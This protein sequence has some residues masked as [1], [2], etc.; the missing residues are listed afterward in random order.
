M[1]ICSS[2]SFAASH[3][4]SGLLV[5]RSPNR[6]TSSG[7][8]SLGPF[9]RDGVVGGDQQRAIVRP[10]PQL[11]GGLGQDRIARGR[12]QLRDRPAE[13]GIGLPPGH[14]QAAGRGLDPLGEPIEHRLVGARS[15]RRYGVKGRIAPPFER[16]RIRGRHLTLHRNGSEWLPP[17]NVEMHRTRAEV[18]QRQGVG[19]AGNRAEV[20]EALVVRHMRADFA[21]PADRIAVELELVDRLARADVAELRRPIGSEH[22]HRHTRLVG[23]DDGRVEVGGGRSGGAQH[24]GRDP[25]GEGR[26]EREEAGA[27]LIED[28][29]SPRSRAAARGRRRVGWSASRARGPPCGRRS[30]PAPRPSRRRGR[31]CGWLRPPPER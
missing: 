27:A 4:R 13:P 24:D 15:S 14:D 8:R 30:G 31:C 22:D 28:H 16:E 21:E 12:G 2:S 11:G 5:G 9:P 18:T 23:L 17:G 25:G 26:P 3:C 1:T 7:A 10:P 6:I 20:E 29:S 19:A